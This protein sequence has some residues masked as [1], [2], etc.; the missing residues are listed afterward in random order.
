MLTA[1]GTTFGKSAV[2]TSKIP[3]CGVVTGVGAAIL[4]ALIIHAAP[5]ASKTIVKANR[6][7]NSRDM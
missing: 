6:N 7:R 3:G 2:V 4:P 1:T 5:S